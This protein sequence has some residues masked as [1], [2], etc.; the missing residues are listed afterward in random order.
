MPKLHEL[1]WE[2][3]PRPAQA[4]LASYRLLRMHF[5][6]ELSTRVPT[7]FS[8]Q[9]S[10]FVF[11]DESPSPVPTFFSLLTSVFQS[12]MSSLPVVL[13][14]QPTR[15]HPETQCAGTT[16]YPRGGPVSGPLVLADPNG[17]PE[18]ASSEGIPVRQ[19][20]EASSPLRNH[21][22]SARPHDATARNKNC[23]ESQG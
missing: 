12:C 21:G 8:H 18:E 10:Q 23:P 11:I 7:I 15:Q 16:S 17:L 14:V 6:F 9:F 2:S 1:L 13:S 5:S 3:R 4:N 20:Q 22:G 19:A